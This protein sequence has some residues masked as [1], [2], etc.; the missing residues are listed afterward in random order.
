[1]AEAKAGALLI[2]SSTID[3]DT[4]RRVA[5]AAEAASFNMVDA[6]VSGGVGG[7]SAGTL[8]FMVGGSAD[9][10]AAAKPILDVMGQNIFHAGGNG[11]GQVAKI[12]N[13]MLLGISMIGTCEAFMLGEK[14]G[15]EAQTLFDISATAS[16]QC[17]S[18]TSYCPAPGPVPT[19]PSNNQY[20]AGFAAAMMLKDLNL[21]QEASGSAECQTPM[22]KRAA[23]LYTEMAEKGQGELDFSGIIKMLQGA[24]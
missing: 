7:A 19:A 5:A 1:L 10:F 2:D 15:L 12:C 4:A 8:T 11:N 20:Q 21:A 18:M 16:G 24:F 3:V 13:N 9:G 6:P 14:L 22:G 17:W 23:E